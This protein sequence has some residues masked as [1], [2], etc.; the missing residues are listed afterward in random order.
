[1]DNEKKENET[2]VCLSKDI[3]R[4]TNY[5]RMYSKGR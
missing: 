1:M 3:G 2:S 4:Q 5:S